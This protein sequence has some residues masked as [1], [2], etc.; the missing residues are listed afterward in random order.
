MPCVLTSPLP[1]P[2]ARRAFPLVTLPRRDERS[3]WPLVQVTDPRDDGSSRGTLWTTDVVRVLHRDGRV[4]CVVNRKGRSRLLSCTNCDELAVCETCGGAMR[5]DDIGELVCTNMGH[6]R[7]VVCAACGGTAFKNLRIGVS[8]AR[9]ELEALLREPV[10]EVTGETSDADLDGARVVVGTEAVLHRLSGLAAVVFADFDQELVAPRYR[11]AEEAL[12]LIVRAGR[13]VG[14]RG[15]G[16]GVVLVQ[17]RQPSHPV[18]RA[19]LSAD[20]E[21]WASGESARRELLGYPPFAAVAQLSGPGANEFVER[22]G[23]PLGIELRGPLDGAWLA[24]AADHEVLAD[25]LNAVERPK[26]RLRIAVDPV[27]L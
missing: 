24:R 22:L 8:R 18:L 14:G 10:I 5:Q 6:R 7:P 1:T 16:S 13:L 23:Q 3:G 27:R 21:Q 26:E 19:A 15:S 12:A 17:T 9:E 20:V 2:E 11:A 4:A 25:A